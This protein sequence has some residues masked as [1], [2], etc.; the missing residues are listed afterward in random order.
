MSLDSLTSGN[1][2]H[3]I[4]QVPLP[5]KPDSEDEALLRKWKWKVRSV[6]KENRERHSQRCDIELKLAVRSVYLYML[7][8]Y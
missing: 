7:L 2:Y 6:K 8:E 3:Q 1:Y 4:L 5:E